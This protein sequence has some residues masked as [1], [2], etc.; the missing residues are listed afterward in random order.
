MKVIITSIAI[1]ACALAVC[2]FY[3]LVPKLV[4]LFFH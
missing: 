4:H 1:V 2:A 3:W